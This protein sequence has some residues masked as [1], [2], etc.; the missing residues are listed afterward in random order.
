VQAGKQVRDQAFG[1]AGR[2]R[3]T[4]RLATMHSRQTGVG[5]PAGSREQAGRAC[6]EGRQDCRQVISFR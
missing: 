3:K 2:A 1:Q 6:L 5:E 4:Y